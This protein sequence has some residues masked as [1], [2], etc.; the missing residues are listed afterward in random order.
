MRR[1]HYLKLR[2][3]STF[4]NDIPLY[5]DRQ[6]NPYSREY[7]ESKCIGE[8]PVEPTH[9]IRA[10]VPMTNVKL[11]NIIPRKKMFLYGDDIPLKKILVVS[12]DSPYYF[13]SDVQDPNALVPCLLIPGYGD[14][15]LG[16]IYRGE[17]YKFVA[18][19]V[20]QP[21]MANGQINP[22]PDVRV[23]HYPTSVEWF[24]INSNLNNLVCIQLNP[25]QLLLAEKI[26]K[27][28][29]NL[30]YYNPRIVPL[31]HFPIYKAINF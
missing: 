8:Y 6:F 9:G 13:T 7:E 27:N 17:N 3:D 16:F 24:M 26:N 2:E 30:D 11:I 21:L 20:D 1:R 28:E 5:T 4:Q 10:N 19:Y 18:P 29:Y 12:C 31:E 14:N 25:N 23:E 22:N 15:I